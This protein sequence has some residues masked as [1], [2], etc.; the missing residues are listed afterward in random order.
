MRIALHIIVVIITELFLT[1]DVILFLS[2][3]VYL[4]NRFI[5]SYYL[6]A[7]HLS[8]V[9]IARLGKSEYKSK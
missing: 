1:E 9:N 6:A 5:L 8:R 4:A 3:I 2:G 7:T